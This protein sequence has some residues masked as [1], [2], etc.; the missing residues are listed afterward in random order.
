[1]SSGPIKIR[2]CD[3]F[4]EPY[5]SARCSYCGTIEFAKGN[6]TL[7]RL[8]KWGIEHIKVCEKIPS[9]RNGF[10]GARFLRDTPYKSVSEWRRAMINAIPPE[11]RCEK[12][13]GSGQDVIL[14]SNGGVGEI[15]SCW[16]CEG[17]G[18]KKVFK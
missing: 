8:E 16:P 2:T 10:K 3:L 13:K 6:G 12:C 7:S 14:A 9:E 5:D 11:E 15:V 1:M 4:E 18:R 17:S